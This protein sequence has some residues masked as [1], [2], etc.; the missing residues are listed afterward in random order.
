MTAP[1][2]S[3]LQGNFAEAEPLYERSHA[4]CETVLDPEH[5]TVASSLNNRVALLLKQ[6]SWMLRLSKPG[7]VVECW[8]VAMITNVFAFSYLPGAG[9]RGPSRWTVPKTTS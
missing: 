3:S 4:I 8:C 1:L 9:M 2:F 6:A 5:P 7:A